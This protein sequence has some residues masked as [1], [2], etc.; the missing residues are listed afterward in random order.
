[1]SGPKKAIVDAFRRVIESGAYRK[2]WILDEDFVKIICLE[3]GLECEASLIN[4]LVRTFTDDLRYDSVFKNS[5]TFPSGGV[6]RR[7]YRPLKSKRTVYGYFVADSTGIIT[8]QATG[9]DNGELWYTVASRFSVPTKA[10]CNIAKSDREEALANE[11]GAL[12]GQNPAQATGEDGALISPASDANGMSS[13]DSSIIPESSNIRT[14]GGNSSMRRPL[15]REED[16]DVRGRED[17]DDDVRGFFQNSMHPPLVLSESTWITPQLPSMD[18]LLK[19]AEMFVEKHRG[20]T[21][22]PQ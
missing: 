20:R 21:T 5:L 4:A 17:E 22:Q 19:A 7:E 6:S 1:M 12:L 10:V 2:E 3:Y 14:P 15:R 16:D 8:E 9:L 11:L 13:R 18:S